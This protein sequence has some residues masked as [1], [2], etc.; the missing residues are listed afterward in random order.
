MS[1]FFTMGGYAGYVWSAYAITLVVI[2]LNVWSARR[3][4]AQKLEQARRATEVHTDTPRRRAKV[5]QL[6]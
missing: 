5:R 6:Q 2:V 4:T 3:L 1:D